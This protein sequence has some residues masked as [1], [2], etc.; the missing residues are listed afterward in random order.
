MDN[1]Y[2]PLRGQRKYLLDRE[3]LNVM[4][5]YID[6]LDVNVTGITFEVPIKEVTG[7]CIKGLR[8]KV[9]DSSLFK[10]EKYNVIQISK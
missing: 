1:I 2:N 9:N 3:P 4:I 8:S 7:K 5:G 6:M 10:E